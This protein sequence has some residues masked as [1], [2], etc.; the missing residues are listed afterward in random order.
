MRSVISFFL[1]I[2]QWL[3]TPKPGGSLPGQ[4]TEEDLR[5]WVISGIIAGLSWLLVMAPQWAA[6]VDMGSLSATW[7]LIVGGIVS[8]GW[9]FVRSLPDQAKVPANTP[10][11]NSTPE[12]PHTSG[13]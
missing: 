1:A 2:H 10:S 12:P 6:R 9:K 13:S 11:P 8:L 4:I 7:L 3:V 5:R